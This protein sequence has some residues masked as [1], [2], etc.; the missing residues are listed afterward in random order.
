MKRIIFDIE[1]DGLEPTKIYVFSWIEEGGKDVKS[2]NDYERMRQVIS[3]ADELVGHNII[4]FDI[5]VLERLL[6][7]KVDAKLV[8][9]LALSWYLYPK[10]VLHGLEWW[11]E[12]FG[13]PKPTITDWDGLTYEEYRHRC[14][15]DV[16]ITRKLFKKQMSYLNRLYNGKP[17]KLIR[18]LSWKLNCV[19]LSEESGWKLDIDA[20]NRNLDILE[21]EFEARRQSLLR[22]M[23][24]VPILKVATR[25]KKPYKADGTLSATG[26][27]WEDLTR[28]HGFSFDHPGGF[29]YRAGEKEPNP[30][31]VPQVKDWLYSLG[32]KPCTFKYERD[33]ETGDTRKIPQIK[34][35]DD[36]AN[37][38][39]SVLEL[40]EETPAILELAGY[41]MLKH[42]IGILKGFLRDV[43]TDGNLR[44]GIGG[45][46]N[47]LRFKHREIVNLPGVSAPYGKLIRECLVAR[48]GMELCGSDQSSLEDRT[49]QHYM[50]PHDPE[51]VAAMQ[52]PGFDSHLDLALSNG[53]ITEE[54]LASYKQRPDDYPEVTLLRKG[55]KV[56]NYSSL[57]GV[58]GETLSRTLKCSVSHA[59]GLIEVYWKRNWSVLK[60]AEDCTVKTVDKQKWL[61]NPVSKLWYSLRAEKDRFST[62]NQGTGVYCFDTWIKY[63][64]RKRPQLTGQFHDE[65]ILEI[66]KGSRDKCTALLEWA[67]EQAN[68]E[69]G[70]NVK[71]SFGIDFGH[72][73]SDIH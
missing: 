3:E 27:K 12:D 18:Y 2:T 55:Y 66:K 43:R 17:Q 71:L 59:N 36:G 20:V 61:F 57:Y 64:I 63:I 23:P 11:G 5:P 10:R 25:P 33:K 67:Q 51:Y 1:G 21:T 45:F 72:A 37:L 65:I 26:K 39:A 58:R 38:S 29:K 50:W 9:T 16:K 14:E 54:V 35:E 15:E 28:E 48:D 53:D 73:Y 6:S 7:I 13:I 62:L 46:T 52:T 4:L 47:T 22:G 70:L 41:G 40:A 49:K 56:V 44:A 68:N 24:P 19:R 69:L 30:N 31:S 34:D 8:D 32:W 42:R 60:V